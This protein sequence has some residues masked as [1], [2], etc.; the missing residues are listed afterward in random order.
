MHNQ[1]RRA[2]RLHGLALILAL[3]AVGAC[4]SADVLDDGAAD[5][6]DA[7]G[8]RR[9][10]RR[11]GDGTC[12]GTETCSTCAAD[13]GACPVVDAGA[14]T[15]PVSDVTLSPASVAFG[16]VV[17]GG[18]SDVK[19]VTITNTGTQP[20]SFPTP[21]VLAGDFV[22]GGLG[23]CSTSSPVAPGASCTA[24]MKFSPTGAGARAGSLTITSSSPSAPATVALTGTGVAS[25]PPSPPPP[26]PLSA[27]HLYVATTGS[28]SS[29]GTQAAPFRTIQKA[30]NV[31]GADTTVHVASGTYAESVYGTK[32]GTA[33][34]R[35]RFV[36]DL[37]WGAKIVPPSSSS[38]A[39]A[40][41][42]RGAYVTVDGFEVDGSVDPASGT[43][44]TVG[45]NVAGT[46]SVVSR[47]LVH[48]I[49]NTGSANGNGGA[50]IL[51]DSWY[52]FNDMQALDNVVHHV[53]PATG[54]SNWY[55]GI[56]QTATGAIQNNIVYANAG[57]GIHLW[58][59]VNHVNIANNTSFGNG[60]GFIV[61]GGDFVHTS[62]PADYITVTNNIAFDNVDIGFDE[63]GAVG[64]HNLFANNLSFQNARNWRLA[65]SAHTGDVAADP[66]FVNYL[67]AGGGD[68]HLKTSSPAIDKGI[69]SY[70]PLVDFD[71]AARPYGL[72]FDI[73]AYEW[74]P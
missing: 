32:S 62:G 12:S 52:G 7:S 73:G 39:A 63:E 36:S 16:D 64:S 57:G 44:W 28:D 25:L 55:H 48:H 53:G 61:G 68:Y 66:Q 59:D 20:L 38:R 43:K 45:I 74:H 10:R 14:G 46:G 15:M 60:H 5:E 67:R 37:K 8:L 33:S 54:G 6:V 22:F 31:A 29:S 35:L 4:T 49:F 50:G 19:L 56:Y 3:F 11:C 41:D 9:A 30:V 13:C 2:R 17:L 24:S 65:I 42:S 23:T 72:A 18:T 27:N 47:T 58:H 40:F 51:L 71:G 70:A 1:E 26:G 21:F 34:G 69:P